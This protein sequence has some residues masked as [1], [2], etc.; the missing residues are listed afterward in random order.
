MKKIRA[1][2]KKKEKAYHSKFID[3]L[4]QVLIHLSLMDVLW[5]VLKYAKYIN[6][7]M[8]NKI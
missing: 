6:E 4:K 3:L 2:M 5:G 7:I 8:A 1:L